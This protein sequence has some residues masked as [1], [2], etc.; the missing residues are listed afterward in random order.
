MRLHN[1][2]DRA[3]LFAKTAVNALEQIDVVTRGAATAVRALFGI[4]GDRQRR[5]NRLAQFAGDATLFAIGIAAQRLQ[6][7]ETYRLRVLIERVVDRLLGRERVLQGHP[8]A[9]KSVA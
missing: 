7:A 8:L 1:R 2:I 5:S 6:A 4:D 3:R 9:R